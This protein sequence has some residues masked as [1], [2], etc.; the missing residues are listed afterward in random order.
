MVMFDPAETVFLKKHVI[1][2][3]LTGELSAAR[4]AASLND[5]TPDVF[6]LFCFSFGLFW[7]LLTAPLNSFFGGGIRS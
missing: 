2:F 1:F 4:D 3:T 7:K 5:P 6:L